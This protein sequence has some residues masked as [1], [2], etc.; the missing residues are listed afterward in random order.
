[1]L[2]PAVTGLN[3][4][5]DVKLGYRVQWVGFDANPKTA[6]VTANGR[7]KSISKKNGTWHGVGIAV[8]SDNTGPTS[9]TFIKGSYA[10]HLKLNH[11]TR[12]AMGI[13][14]GAFQYRLDA[15]KV[16]LYQP[17]DPAIQGSSSNF[18]FPIITPGLW[19]Y[20]KNYYLGV[21][22]HHAKKL[23]LQGIG[24]DS[25]Y[26]S[27]FNFIGG[28]ILGNVHKISYIPALE[29]KATRNSKLAVD[30]N[31]WA[32]YKNTIS[33][34]LGYR[35][36]DAASGM[37]KFNFLKYFTLCYA[38]D[39][40]LSPIKNGSSNTHEIILGFTACPRTLRQGFVP[41]A[42]YD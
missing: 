20:S 19:L 25:Y 4:C 33:L 1:M 7:I 36:E 21:A 30:V 23:K 16:R 3:E 38:Y 28:T 22:Y 13:F 35:N 24:E 12:L 31:F 5:L 42:A 39:F 37:L 27:T 32:D 40:T 17:N 9:R 10:I 18:L 15:S 11:T 41:C 8:E 34:G 2:N 29:V 26:Y 6:F 14:L